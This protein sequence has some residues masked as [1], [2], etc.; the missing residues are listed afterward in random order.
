ML[1]LSESEVDNDNTSASD[2]RTAASVLCC[3]LLVKH[4]LTFSHPVRYHGVQ[5]VDR[6]LKKKK[7]KLT[8]STGKGHRGYQ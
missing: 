5:C 1:R 7:K 6:K 4:W 3:Q 8:F 2:Q